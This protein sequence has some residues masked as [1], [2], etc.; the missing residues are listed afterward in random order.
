[1]TL[2]NAWLF[3]LSSAPLGQGP[4]AGP[5]RTN[6]PVDLCDQRGRRKFVRIPEPGAS[7]P[8][9]RAYC[10]TTQSLSRTA[11]IVKKSKEPVLNTG[12]FPREARKAQDSGR[13]KR[14]R[15][16]WH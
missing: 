15:A 11:A 5:E 7:L 6:A 1:V 16:W 14:H 2:C 13:A 8:P 9:L 12:T 3:E 10:S 4:K